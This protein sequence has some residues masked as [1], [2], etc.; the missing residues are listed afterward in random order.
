MSR[1]PAVLLA[2]ALALACGGRSRTAA[3]P[4]PPPP[5]APPPAPAV[6]VQALQ[7]DARGH[8]AAGD[9]DGA[10]AKLEQA[11]AA[12]PSDGLRLD[13][14]DLLVADGRDLDAAAALD[15]D[16]RDRD[17]DVRY[18]LLS[19]RLAE[20]RGDDAAAADAYA[21]AVARAEDADV[22]LR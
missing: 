1:T 13:L 18:D 19:A 10:R 16:V 14:A 2:A 17:P 7:A 6:D 9:L 11:L 20:L 5:P 22:R 12:A 21:R 3:A 4:P 8:R 15:A